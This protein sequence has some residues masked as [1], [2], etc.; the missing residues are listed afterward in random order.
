M[1]IATV[2][3]ERRPVEA[4]GGAGVAFVG[5]GGGVGGVGG[6]VGVVDV[7]VVVVVGREG[8]ALSRGPTQTGP[9]Q[10]RRSLDP[11]TFG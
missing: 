10:K 9:T 5:V 1:F 4:Q 2:R 3:T 8:P 11:S 6:V 7:D